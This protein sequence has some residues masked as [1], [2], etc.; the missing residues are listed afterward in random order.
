MIEKISRP[1]QLFKTELDLWQRLAGQVHP[2]HI[3]AA[4][5]GVG[6]A[7]KIL[8]QDQARSE[9]H[10]APLW[11][12]QLV[13]NPDPTTLLEAAKALGWKDLAVEQ[14]FDI[15]DRL[16]CVSAPVEALLLADGDK[17]STLL[18]ETGVNAYGC[19]PQPQPGSILLSAC[20]G[21]EIGPKGLICAQQLRQDLMK[22]AWINQL[23][24]QRSAVAQTHYEQIAKIIGLEIG[25]QDGIILTESG[26]GAIRQAAQFLCGETQ[27]WLYIL[28]GQKESGREVPEAVR[29]N[30]Q[31]TVCSIEVRN[32]QSGEPV[33]TAQIFNQ[34]VETID[35]AFAQ[36][37]QVVLQVVEGSK[38]GL[39][40]PGIEAVRALKQRFPSGLSLVADFCQMRPGTKARDYWALGAVIVAT[41]SKFLGGPVFSGV[42]LL[43]GAGTKLTG[44]A[45]GI[46]PIPTIGT[47]LRW[48]AALAESEGLGHLAPQQIKAGLQA[49]AQMVSDGCRQSQNVSVVADASPAHIVAILIKDNEQLDQLRKL[50]Q[51]L[52]ADATGLLPLGASPQDQ[53]LMAVRCLI[54]QPLQ[55]GAT[56][57]LRLAINAGRLVSLVVDKEGQSQLATD[58]KT[59]LRKIDL[60]CAG[61]RQR[62]QGGKPLF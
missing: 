20:S 16:R 19:A 13:A 49:F 11:L 18:A 10:K 8:P 22:A 1:E 54:G 30:P 32:P 15:F 57:A 58:I 50:H 52:I 36:G 24:P 61:L 53:Q 59:V 37:K 2:A 31:I 51:W 25:D 23:A 3:L 41:G 45:V 38:T 12:D 9:W 27:T 55:L 28:V 42:A 62:P 5:H 17:R 29:C 26:T 4:A 7:M 47:A 6:L 33:S 14:S 34:L 21:N 60:V 44:G 39:V 43:P 56:A 35:Q 40:A 46:R 48:H